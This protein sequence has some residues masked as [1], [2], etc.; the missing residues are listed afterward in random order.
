MLPCN[1]VHSGEIDTARR[2]LGQ[3]SKEV[4]ATWHGTRQDRMQG[5]DVRR[6]VPRES[7]LSVWT[8]TMWYTRACHKS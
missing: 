5:S 6:D 4:E 8:G 2:R 1:A 3:V 7:K